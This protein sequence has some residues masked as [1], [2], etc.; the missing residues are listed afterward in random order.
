MTTSV[1]IDQHIYTIFERKWRE[2]REWM[3]LRDESSVHLCVCVWHA[4]TCLYIR[5]H[6]DIN[7]IKGGE[8]LYT[9]ISLGAKQTVV[10][11]QLIVCRIRPD[12]IE[13]MVAWN[14]VNR[15]GV[16]RCVRLTNNSTFG[17]KRLHCYYYYKY[18]N[19][20]STTNI[21]TAFLFRTPVWE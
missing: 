7:W 15:W 12:S 5:T 19:S 14:G 9:V 18:P 21:T 10:H 17:G 11:P 8:S 6:D 4:T 2:L 16:R 1:L 20:A 3:R 13:M